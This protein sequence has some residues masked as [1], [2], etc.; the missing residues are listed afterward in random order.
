[1]DRTLAFWLLSLPCFAQVVP[2]GESGVSLG[3]LHFHSDNPA[4][5]AKFWTEVFGAQATKVGNLELYKLPGMFI[6]LDPSKPTGAMAGS[7]VPSI[8]LKVR[9]L[10]AILERAK[11]ASARI[12]DQSSS[13]AVIFGPDDV[14]IEMTA[15]PTLPT[16][17]GGESIQVTIP[18]TAAARAWYEKTFGAIA[19]VK[20]E[21]SKSETPPEATKGRV[22]DHIGFEITNLKEFTRK[23]AASGQKV[24]L[25]YLK[26]PDSGVAIGFV[27]D[28]WGTFIEL[29]E[30]LIR[31]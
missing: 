1:M 31:F 9:D 22:L 6:A 29:T 2:P 3:H 5:H 8:G 4:A 10:A 24:D 28:P 26:L 30:G 18:D 14:R 23:L 25:M 12:Q 20:L 13:H 7:T 11:A 21:F 17:V 16:A 15:E 19:G 27:T